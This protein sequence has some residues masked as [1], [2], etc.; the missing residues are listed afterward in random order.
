MLGLHGGLL[1]ACLS[2]ASASACL[3]VG[4]AP[5]GRAATP[6]CTGRWCRSRH[7]PALAA[8]PALAFPPPLWL[9]RSACGRTTGSIPRIA[10]LRHPSG[11]LGQKRRIR[12][13]AA[14]G[15]KWRDGKRPDFFC[16]LQTCMAMGTDVAGVLPLPRLIRLLP[17]SAP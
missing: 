13:E 14:P 17:L 12:Y 16:L 8:R 2:D 6:G 4:A 7:R 5:A 15:R 9:Q 10:W 3:G 1:F 11:R